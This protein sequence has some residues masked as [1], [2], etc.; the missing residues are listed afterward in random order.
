MPILILWVDLQDLIIA[1]RHVLT[2]E[3]RTLFLAKLDSLMDERILIGPGVAS[4]EGLR[5]V[6]GAT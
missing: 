1:I 6:L 2:E 5:R 3:I 4:R